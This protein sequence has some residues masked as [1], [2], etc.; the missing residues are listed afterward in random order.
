MLSLSFHWAFL[1]KGETLEAWDASCDCA[2]TTPSSLLPSDPPRP[3]WRTYLR[4]PSPHR[5]IGRHRH[6]ASHS[7]RHPHQSRPRADYAQRRPAGWPPQRA[8]MGGS[9]N[10]PGRRGASFRHAGRSRPG[11][12]CKAGSE[13]GRIRTIL[14]ASPR[15]DPATWIGRIR[16]GCG[17]R[18]VADR[19]HPTDRSVASWFWPIVHHHHEPRGDGTA[20]TTASEWV[21][22]WGVGSDA[23]Q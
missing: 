11:K 19:H 4:S 21:W 7:R 14:S 6:H 3:R 2:G 17:G 15:H 10:L 12:L 20:G 5:S 16:S 9:A 22:L 13:R 18:D 23:W 8:V 1:V